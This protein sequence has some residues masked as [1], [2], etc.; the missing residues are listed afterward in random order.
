MSYWV[1]ANPA[2]SLKTDNLDVLMK[3]LKDNK[4]LIQRGHL[5]IC[6]TIKLDVESGSDLWKMLEQNLGNICVLENPRDKFDFKKVPI[7]TNY[8]K[9]IGYEC[10]CFCCH[11]PKYDFYNICR[12]IYVYE[13]MGKYYDNGKYTNIELINEQFVVTEKEIEDINE[14]NKQCYMKICQYPSMFD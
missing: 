14:K 8:Y 3:A 9:R 13:R 4:T 6:E 2:I 5:I 1:F 10:G 12:T 11:C 7:T